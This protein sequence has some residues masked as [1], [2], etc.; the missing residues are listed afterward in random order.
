MVDK[1][2]EFLNTYD[3]NEEYK[4]FVQSG[5]TSQENVDGRFQYWKSIVNE[6]N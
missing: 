6:L 5:T 1:I 3:D 4:F 2:T